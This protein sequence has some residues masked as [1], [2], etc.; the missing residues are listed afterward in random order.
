MDAQAD[1][2]T[3]RLVV[4]G[5]ERDRLYDRF[6][7]LF[8]GRDGVEVLKDRRVSERRRDR[9]RTAFERRSRERRRTAPDWVVPPS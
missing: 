4:T 8:W 2:A 1:T 6:C 7:Q 3:Y 5:P 9:S